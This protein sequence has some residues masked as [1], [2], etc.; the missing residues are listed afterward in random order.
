MITYVDTSVLM[1]LIID[2]PGSDHAAVAWDTADD[3]ATC[4]ITHAEA[5]AAL[6]AAARAGRLAITAHQQALNVLEEL[7]AQMFIAD[8]DEDLVRV[9]GDLAE[10]HALRG[11]DAVHLAAALRV[12]ASIMATSDRRLI[13]AAGAR[14][15]H[16][17]AP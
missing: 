3:L 15:M 14:S 13:A 8:A 4:V 7:W 2:E 17:A 9:A 6:A 16:V 11:Y 12:A 10:L 5:R 1:K